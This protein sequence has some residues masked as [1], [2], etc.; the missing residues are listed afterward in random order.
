MN[1]FE[2]DYETSFVWDENLYLTKNNIENFRLYEIWSRSLKLDNSEPQNVFAIELM[3]NLEPPIF[4]LG[5]LFLISESTDEIIIYDLQGRSDV[6]TC[7]ENTGRDDDPRYEEYYSRNFKFESLIPEELTYE[8]I[9][10]YDYS[11]KIFTAR[12]L[13]KFFHNDTS[14]ELGGLTPHLNQ[15]DIFLNA[16]DGF[17]LAVHQGNLVRTK[18]I[19][20]QRATQVICDLKSLP[21]YSQVKSIYHPEKNAVFC[22]FDNHYFF[23]LDLSNNTWKLNKMNL[24]ISDFTIARNPYVVVVTSTDKV[25]IKQLT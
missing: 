19:F 5:H 12:N 15:G 8:F 4:F 10:G 17:I 2:F 21:S 9:L 1:V 16:S 6:Y 13:K 22:L 7:Y 18:I 20:N 24:D 14:P 3:S 25:V 11:F 23:K